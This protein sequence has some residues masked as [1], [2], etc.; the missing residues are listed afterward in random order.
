MTKRSW[1]RRELGKDRIE[2]VLRSAKSIS[3]AARTLGVNKST[4]SRWAKL[5]GPPSG[6]VVSMPLVP[7]D[8]PPPEAR[9][10]P[11]AWAAW[12]RER[13]ELSATKD[14]L[15]SLAVT[16]LHLAN[17]TGQSASARIQAAGRYQQIVKQLDFEAEI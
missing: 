12:I 13:Y 5:M 7:D 15:L 1:R 3:E 11:E 4:A 8:E 16:C 9:T 6:N 2:E 14:Q 17:D 10:D